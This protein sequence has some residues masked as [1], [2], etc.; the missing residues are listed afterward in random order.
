MVQV[1]WIHIQASWDWLMAMVE[2][3][4]QL[5]THI[6]VTSFFVKW[7]FWKN[8]SKEAS[9]ASKQ[10]CK[11]VS[12]DGSRRHE[13]GRW[14]RLPAGLGP[15]LAARQSSDGPRWGSSPLLQPDLGWQP[16]DQLS[17]SFFSSQVP[18]KR[19]WEEWVIVKNCFSTVKPYLRLRS[20]ESLPSGLTCGK[21]DAK[22]KSV[23]DSQKKKNFIDSQKE[24]KLTKDCSCSEVE[25]KG[26]CTHVWRV[27][28]AFQRQIRKRERFV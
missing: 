23:V 22:C 27:V 7:V 18:V 26:S 4:D 1:T 25:Q 12:K 15:V 24:E 28:I 17:G 10:A 6:G 16:A 3:I 8:I 5:S 9:I 13:T 21:T 2:L 20:A 11:Q 19:K 14:R